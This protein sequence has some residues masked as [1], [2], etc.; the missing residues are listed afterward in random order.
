MLLNLG[1]IAVS[2][3]GV[4]LLSWGG[5]QSQECNSNFA[6]ALATVG[7]SE[8]AEVVPCSW[9]RLWA[10]AVSSAAAQTADGESAE[11][12]SPG[13]PAPLPGA[14]GSAP[15]KTPDGESA[16]VTSPSEAEPLPAAEEHRR[17]AKLKSEPAKATS[18]SKAAR[19]S[20]AI[21]PVA[22]TEPRAT[23]GRT[24]PSTPDSGTDTL[25]RRRRSE[26]EKRFFVV[27]RLGVLLRGDAHF[28][29]SCTSSGD[30]ACVPEPG[31]SY[32]DTSTV[33][34]ELDALYQFLGPFR[35]GAALG[36]VPSVVYEASTSQRRFGMELTGGL[37]LEA[38]VPVSKRVSVIARVQGGPTLLIPGRDLDDEAASAQRDCDA[39]SAQGVSCRVETGPYLGMTYGLSAGASYRLEPL[40]GLQFRSELAYQHYRID[41]IHQTASTP[42]GHVDGDIELYGSR[43]WLVTG[44]EL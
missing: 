40:G 18:S 16:E 4:G 37:I 36:W 43:I 29:E 23:P 34:L 42:N 20:P 25:V 13:E 12:G 10:D 14:A 17:D 1:G 6:Q 11:V 27:P 26:P 9:W 22:T 8:A 31:A 38:S 15:V 19:V 39:V 35:F 44:V 30:L 32:A 21:D 2:T 41:T 33:G 7:Y 5:L 24:G 28:D 3:V